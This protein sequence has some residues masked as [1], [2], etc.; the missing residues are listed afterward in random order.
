M[1][2]VSHVQHLPTVTSLSAAKVG[3]KFFRSFCGGG[4][5]EIASVCICRSLFVQPHGFTC[6]EM[7]MPRHIRLAPP[8]QTLD[9][10]RNSPACV[11]GFFPRFQRFMQYA[12]CSGR[13]YNIFHNFEMPTKTKQQQP[14]ST[15]LHWHLD[16]LIDLATCSDI[17]ATIPSA[18]YHSMGKSWYRFKVFLYF[19]S[20]FLT[21]HVLDLA[22]YMLDS[23]LV[24]A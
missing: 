23:V 11:L 22:P 12:M 8:P 18:L 9:T 5:I 19:A 16:R 7:R 3:S 10:G 13:I 17:F 2:R 24:A 1:A 14:I 21:H 4:G 20:F 6:A 15:F